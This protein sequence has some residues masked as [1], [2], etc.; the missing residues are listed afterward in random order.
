LSWWRE[1]WLE[2]L[3]GGVGFGVGVEVLQRGERAQGLACLCI[4]TGDFY[5][6]A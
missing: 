6:V 2:V 3:V 1:F 5:M 4:V